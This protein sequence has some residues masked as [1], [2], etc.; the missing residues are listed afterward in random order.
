MNTPRNNNININS[1][2]EGDNYLPNSSQKEEMVSLLI[3]ILFKLI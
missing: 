2:Q 1:S 3:L